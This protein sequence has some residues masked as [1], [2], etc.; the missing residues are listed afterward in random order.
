M[1]I[2][3]TGGAG[4]IGSNF[5]HYWSSFYPDQIRVI[6]SLTY[7]GN[8]SSLED[9]PIDFR[10]ADITDIASVMEAMDGIDIVVNF[11][12]ET[13]VDRSRFNP[14]GF[15]KANVYGTQVLLR[16]A[17][18]AGVKRFHHVSTDE[19]FGALPLD[20]KEKFNENTPHNPNPNNKYAVSKAEADALVREFHLSHI[21]EIKIT[22]SN[23]SNNFGPYHYPEKFIPLAV[24]NLLDGLPIP[25]Y[26]DGLYVRDWLHTIDHARAIDTILRKGRNGE[27]YMIGAD[28]EMANIDVAKMVLKLMGKDEREFRQV[29]DRPSHDRRY[30]VDATKLKSLGWK[31]LYDRNNFE[32]GLKD[33][34]EWYRNNEDWWRPL[35]TKEGPV[36]DKE[37]VLVGSIGINRELGGVKFKPVTSGQ[38]RI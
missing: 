16:S 25:L 37:G 27:S 5:V 32:A 3:V 7:A 6:D 26:G 22:S 36:Y 1:K 10:E 21:D 23:C 18:A 29:P 19:V 8:K 35:L 20:S 31:P 33:T 15:F 12:A 38:E 13:H 17:L 11:A 2:L 28:C 14:D 34:I 24:T 9:V 30:A 4:F